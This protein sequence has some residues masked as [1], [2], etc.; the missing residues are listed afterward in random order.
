[1][2]SPHVA[3]RPGGDGRAMPGDEGRS[4]SSGAVRILRRRAWQMGPFNDAPSQKSMAMRA[5]SNSL[6]NPEFDPTIP[7]AA[8]RPAPRDDDRAADRREP[9]VSTRICVWAARTWTRRAPA[10]PPGGRDATGASLATT[11]GARASPGR[12][13]A[14]AGA[15]VSFIGCVGDDAYGATARVAEREGDTRGLRVAEG[16]RRHG[17]YQRPDSGENAIVSPPRER[18]AHGLTELDR[19]HRGSACLAMQLEVP[20]SVVDEALAFARSAD[21]RSFLTSAPA[22]PPR[23]SCC[24][25]RGAAAQ[26]DRSAAADRR[27]DIA[28]TRAACRAGGDAVVTLGSEGLGP[29]AVRPRSSPPRPAEAVDTTGAGDT[30]AGTPW[31]GSW[32]ATLR[33]VAEGRRSPP[34]AGD[35]A[36]RIL[37]HAAL[38]EMSRLAGLTSF[39]RVA[40]F[41]LWL[42][43]ANPP[44]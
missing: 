31:R 19:D 44:L 28:E 3:V 26:P 7:S 37:L 30:F 43:A 12:R 21:V 8:A 25:R 41:T 11:P 24:P 27:D 17:P 14:R 40:G 29:E 1:M 34:D 13:P 9:A 5:I 22:Q 18:G 2:N 23:A 39:L 33:E 6:T 32:R 35:A 16:P 38:G 42:N 4:W 10:A 15:E 36:R 20:L